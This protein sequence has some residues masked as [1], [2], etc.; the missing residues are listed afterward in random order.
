MRDYS[1]I[2][3]SQKSSVFEFSY[4]IVRAK[5]TLIHRPAAMKNSEENIDEQNG[6]Q[7]FDQT[8][9]FISAHNIVG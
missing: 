5:S 1:F 9:F 2:V 4:A 3:F 8:S 6:Q 7:P